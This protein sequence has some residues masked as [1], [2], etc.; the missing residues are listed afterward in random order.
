MAT[1]N[2]IMQTL[3]LTVDPH[4]LAS[5]TSRT[6]IRRAAEILRSGGTVAIPTETV[7]GLGANALDASAI[8]KIFA[9]KQRPSWDPLIVH[10]SDTEMLPQVAASVPESA[11]KLIHAFWPGPLT[12]LLPKSDAI[13]DAVT[14]GRPRVGV[15]MPQHPVARAVIQAA[16]IPIAAPSANRFGRTSPTTEEHV[17]EDLDGRIDAILESGETIH[18]LESTVIDVCENPCV[19]YRPG[20][21]SLEQIRAAGVEAVLFHEARANQAA[22]PA[23]LPSPGVGLRH[24]APKAKLI[25]I[26]GSGELQLAAFREAL[27]RAQQNSG[28]LGL[29]LPDAFES[30]ANGS[31]ALI[32]H[33]GKWSDAAELAQRLFAGLRSLDKAGAGVILCPLPAA[34]GIGIAIRDRLLKAAKPE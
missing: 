22:E 13:P 21:V 8:A 16:G 27:L 34:T 14:A 18:G 6:S 2:K 5:E 20:V 9:A 28:T 24:Y 25:L 11:A 12:L 32:Y 29:M 10:I 4:D 15:R 19:V 33:W 31:G 17:A 30:A 23:S 1:Y 7:Y 26:D 3:R